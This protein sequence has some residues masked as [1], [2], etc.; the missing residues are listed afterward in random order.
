V[1]RNNVWKPQRLNPGAVAT[2]ER[3]LG[4]DRRAR[5]RPDQCCVHVLAHRDSHV[6]GYIPEGVETV[7]SGRAYCA[8]QATQ[9]PLQLPRY[10]FCWWSAPGLAAS[11][12][13]PSH[14][15]SYKTLRCSPCEV[16]RPKPAQRPYAARKSRHSPHSSFFTVSLP[17]IR[18]SRTSSIGS[19]VPQGSA[20]KRI[21]SGPPSRR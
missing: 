15:T 14:Q 1:A 20:R 16:G 12:L 5:S 18:V 7:W 19:A 11:I 8:T 4:R 17:L 2:P 3:S 9:V 21:S 10:R 6:C 13:E